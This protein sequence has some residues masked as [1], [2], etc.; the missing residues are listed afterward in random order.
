[1]LAAWIVVVVFALLALFQLALVLGAPWGAFAWGGQVEV[2]PP[3]LRVGSACSILLYAAFAVVVLD[4]AG[5]IDVLSDAAAS[6]GAWVV[7]G[8]S[9][10]GVLVNAVSRSKPERY[11]MTPVCL[12]LAV[13]SFVVATG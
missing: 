13:A 7:F 3:S 11:T 10:V 8:F 2:L 12:V 1:V 6:I 9:A 4:R 5:E